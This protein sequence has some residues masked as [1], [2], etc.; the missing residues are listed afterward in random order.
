[1]SYFSGEVTVTIFS[2]S[3]LNAEWGG[4]G[5]GGEEEGGGH[6]SFWSKFFPLKFDPIYEGLPHP[7]KE[8]GNHKSCFPL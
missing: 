6:C 5:G 4:G 3:F 8:I 7:K 1:M 2:A